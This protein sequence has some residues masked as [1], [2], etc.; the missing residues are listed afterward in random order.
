[1]ER[2]VLVVDDNPEMLTMTHNAWAQQGY[3]QRCVKTGEEAVGNLISAQ[4]FKRD[5][6][7]IALV[8][9]Y[10][11]DVTGKLKYARYGKEKSPTKTA[12][13]NR[14]TIHRRSERHGG[15]RYVRR[16]TKT[17][18]AGVLTAGGIA[19]AGLGSK[20][21]ATVLGDDG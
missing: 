19:G 21:G 4:K 16:N 6:R 15:N 7:L 11:D 13:Y 1:M 12:V 14:E 8:A 2:C 9:D 10:L 5:F 20:N 17:E 3:A 18:K